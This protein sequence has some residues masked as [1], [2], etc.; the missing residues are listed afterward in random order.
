MSSHIGLSCPDCRRPVG[1][2]IVG[3]V[4]KPCGLTAEE[5]K[6]VAQAREEAKKQAHELMVQER[7]DEQMPK[8][9]IDEVYEDAERRARRHH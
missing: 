8:A 5:H 7:I 3:W 9:I 6:R 4:N 2:N 1:K